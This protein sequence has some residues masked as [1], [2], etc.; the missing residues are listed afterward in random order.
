[1][2]VRVYLAALLV[3]ALATSGFKASQ[4]YWFTQDTLTKFDVSGPGWTRYESKV[5]ARMRTE[6]REILGYDRAP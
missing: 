5:A 4:Q 3:S 6:L 2:L 1:V